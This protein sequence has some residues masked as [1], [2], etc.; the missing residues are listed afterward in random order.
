MVSVIVITIVR[1]VMTLISL[2]L[3]WKT[4]DYVITLFLIVQVVLK[5]LRKRTTNLHAIHVYKD[6]V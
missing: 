2:T 3:N 1:I 4:V 6:G 5:A